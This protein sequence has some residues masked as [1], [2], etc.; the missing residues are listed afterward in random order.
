MAHII[1]QRHIK[2]VKDMNKNQRNKMEKSV[3]NITDLEQFVDCDIPNARKSILLE[4]QDIH[5]KRGKREFIDLLLTD[6][7][8]MIDNVNAL[9]RLR[10]LENEARST[11]EAEESSL[12]KRHGMSSDEAFDVLEEVACL[13]EDEKNKAL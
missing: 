7:S 2:H 5:E 3:D 8:V 4:A 6:D 11:L 1:D 13:E 10:L 9:Q 12:I